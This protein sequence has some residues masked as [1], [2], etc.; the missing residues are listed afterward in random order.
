MQ[1]IE[2]K[3]VI[4]LFDKLIINPKRASKKVLDNFIYKEKDNVL[5]YLDRL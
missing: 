2:T 1:L 4:D 5:G 3:E